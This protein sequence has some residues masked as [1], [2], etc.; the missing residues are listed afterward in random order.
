MKWNTQSCAKSP[1]ART[2]VAS[3]PSTLTMNCLESSH[4]MHGEHNP[5]MTYL[6]TWDIF[7]NNIP[8]VAFDLEG[9]PP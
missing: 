6:T 1:L 8:A 7:I 5:L 4:F 9:K 2:R 3:L